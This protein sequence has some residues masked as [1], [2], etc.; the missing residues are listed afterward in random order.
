MK[1]NKFLLIPLVTSSL[2]VS[3]ERHY[4]FETSFMG[5]GEKDIAD[6]QSINSG[7]KKLPGTY[8]VSVFLNKDLILT[9]PVEAREINGT[10][11]PCITDELFENLNVVN[12]IS[13]KELYKGSNCI[14]LEDV[15]PSSSS[16]IDTV[17]QVVNLTIPSGYLNRHNSIWADKSRWDE[18]INTAF[19]NYSISLSERSS[20][21][22]TD[23]YM[24]TQNAVNIGTWRYRNTS[25]LQKHERKSELKSITNFIS[26]P[27]PKYDSEL[28]IGDFN[29]DSYF[30]ENVVLKNG[31]SVGTDESMY[32]DHVR[33]YSPVV[34][35][36]ANSNAT[37]SILQNDSVIYKT[38]VAPGAFEIADL[39]AL[40]TNSPLVVRIEEQD[41]NVKVYSLPYTSSTNLI[42]EGTHRYSLNVGKGKYLN[43]I[44][45]LQ[46]SWLQGLPYSSTVY[47]GLRISENAKYMLSGVSKDMGSLGALS[48]DITKSYTKLKDGSEYDGLMYRGR[49]NKY[50]S[51]TKTSI[52]LTNS[53][54]TKEPFYNIYDTQKD[55][56]VTQQ[57][58][59]TQDGIVEADY[60]NYNFYELKNPKKNELALSVSQYFNKIGSLYVSGTYRDY[61]DYNKNDLTLQA[62]FSSNYNTIGYS[63]NYS[64]IKT[65]Y[66]DKYDN[67]SSLNVS[68]P[69]RVFA[70]RNE[71]LSK[72]SVSY[73]AQHMKS[74]G[75]TQIANV[76]GS[77]FDD[78][79][80]NYNISHGE[81]KN[82]DYNSINMQYKSFMGES[83]AF[84]TNTSGR[85]DIDLRHAGSFMIHSEGFTLGQSINGAAALVKTGNVKDVRFVNRPGVRTDRNGFAI[86]PSLSQYRRNNIKIDT[87]ELNADLETSISVKEVVP[88]NNSIVHAKFDVVQGAKIYAYVT[89]KGEKLPFGSVAKVE[90]NSSMGMIDEFGMLYLSGLKEN[91]EISLSWGEGKS[92]KARYVLDEEVTSIQ[93]K[94]IECV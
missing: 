56:K 88:M 45:I 39:G 55:N 8:F 15:I 37:V 25:T 53:Y 23:F 3:A 31:F 28:K 85:N 57:N 61:W 63:I 9:S 93:R 40:Y 22:N 49:Y 66:N 6:I 87:A 1:R 70:P 18:G 80:L 54:Y 74:S 36:I 7:K 46:F 33:G 11:K 71:G 4:N 2:S 73:N 76:N 84:Y 90:S 10:I 79:K 14:V 50:M 41:G 21:K 68:V 51:D 65:R 30:F 16:D 12:Y 91:G 83:T 59:L 81:S 13:E 69:L 47:G 42:R 89:H 29:T 20:A 38:F 34:Y 27:L 94:E 52:N 72:T 82:Y 44:T 26:R 43:D 86:I 35:G 62:G 75:V 19:S 17:K 78:D 5:L 24:S 92:C 77:A 67:V 32:P 60:Y 48:L 58:I 64:K